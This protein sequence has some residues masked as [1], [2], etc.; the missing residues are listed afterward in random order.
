[1]K[2]IIA[3]YPAYD[4]VEAKTNKD[5]VKEL[6]AEQKLIQGNRKLAANHRYQ[7]L[8]KFM[9]SSVASSALKDNKDPIAAIERAKANGHDLHFIF[10]LGSCLTAHKQARKEYIEVSVGD[11]VYFEGRLF[12]LQAANNNNLHMKE[13]P[14]E[15][16]SLMTIREAR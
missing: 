12:E 6:H 16:Y 1:M 11:K 15:G 14:S 9:I 5:G 10:G 7:H 8:N 3:A 2:N 13:I 4:V